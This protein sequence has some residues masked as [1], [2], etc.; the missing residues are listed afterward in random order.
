SNNTFGPVFGNTRPEHYRMIILDSWGKVL[1]EST[2][3]AQPWN[4][5]FNGQ[6]LQRGVYA[7][8]IEYDLPSFES[9]AVFHFVR[10]G[11]VTLLD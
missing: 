11:T 9:A 4:G 8:F 10:K 6:R 7:W 5:T 2:D 3:P 1:Y